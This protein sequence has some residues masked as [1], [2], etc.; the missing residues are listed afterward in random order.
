MI[1]TCRRCG[2]T[3]RNLLSV[4][5][6]VT[7]I[8]EVVSAG[9]KERLETALMMTWATAALNA[10]GALERQAAADAEDDRRVIEWKVRRT[11]MADRHTASVQKMLEITVVYCPQCKCTWRFDTDVEGAVTAAAQHNATAQPIDT[12][13]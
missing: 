6:C 3:G 10:P 2:C 9:T 8:G 7:C 5:W 13:G 11:G 4:G 12:R 1:G